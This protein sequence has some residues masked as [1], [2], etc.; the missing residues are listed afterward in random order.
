MERLSTDWEN[1]AAKEETSK[2]LISK[3]YKQLIELN[4]K[5]KPNQNM[6]RRSKHTFLRLRHRQPT[7]QNK[8]M[9]IITK[10]EKCTFK[11]QWGINSYQSEW[12]PQKSLQIT[13]SG[14]SVEKG[15]PLTCWWEYKLVQTLWRTVWRFLKK[16]NRVN[17]WSYN[18]TPGHVFAESKC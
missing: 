14:E 17:V 15:N 4:Q 10:L 9:F 12:T 11:P 18:P 7:G 3:I 8:K 5:T 6:G 16:L 13:N 1:I 2:D